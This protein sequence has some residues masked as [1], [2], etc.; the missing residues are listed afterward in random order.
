MAA[1]YGDRAVGVLLSGS[2]SD[3]AR[4]LQAIGASG[5]ITI[6]EDPRTARFPWMPRAALIADGIDFTLPLDD[7]AKTIIALVQDGSGMPSAAR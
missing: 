4:G 6:V 1:A 7:I 3:R 2:G 5:G